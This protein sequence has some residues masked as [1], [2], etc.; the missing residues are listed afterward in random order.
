MKIL[1]ALKLIFDYEKKSCNRT[2]GNW[3]TIQVLLPK[4]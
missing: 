4:E 3:W 1:I 2:H